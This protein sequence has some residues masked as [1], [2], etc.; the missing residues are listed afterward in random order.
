MLTRLYSLLVML[1]VAGAVA[2][3]QV[4]K[5]YRFVNGRWVEEVVGPEAQPDTD[6]DNDWVDYNDLLAD[7]VHGNKL[8]IDT[9]IDVRN[10]MLPTTLFLPMVFDTYDV[11][12]IGDSTVIEAAPAPVPGPLDWVNDRSCALRR[13]QQFRQRYMIDNI[14][15]VKYNINTLPEAPKRFHAFV[16]PT[17]AH[18][19]VEEIAVDHSQVKKTVDAIEVK[20]IHWLQQFEGLIQF[21]QAYNSPNWYQGG[22]N[23]LNTIIQGVYNARL[24]QTFHPNLLFENTVQ[25]KLGLN[26]APDDS[27]RNYS[28]S[29]DNFQINSK[30]GVKAAKRW[31]YSATMQFKT[32]LLNNYKKNTNDL[33]AAFLSPAELNIGIGL[34]YEYATPSG[35][36]KANASIAPLSYNLKI[37]T[38][39]KID[40][41]QFGIDEGHTS[42]SQYGS[43][44]DC[45]LEWK[46]AYN[47]SLN[48]RLTAFSNYK[49]LQGDWENTLS[50]SINRFLS[51]QIYVHL[52]YDS[53][54]GRYEDTKWHKWQLREVLS[55]GFAYKLG[56]L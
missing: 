32:Q 51:T 7:S 36:F 39:D 15:D 27:L 12:L 11:K 55:F 47:I 5:K 43:N 28:I 4:T 37:C 1:I 52:R 18:I 44:I 50:F 45:R 33:T 34:T 41:R 49:Y 10:R 56:R 19:T 13:Y 40:E 26:S 6:V 17:T 48:S 14:G 2:Q 53:T 29:E 23:N 54:T 31:Y 25:Y 3:A 8:D 20:K 38:N 22:N 21:S 35:K 16:D 9:T 24:N 30:F 46:L 42:V